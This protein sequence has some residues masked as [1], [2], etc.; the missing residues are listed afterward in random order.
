MPVLQSGRLRLQASS[1]VLRLPVLNTLL[2]TY[3][4]DLSATV[5]RADG[6]WYLCDDG[7]VGVVPAPQVR[8]AQAFQLFY[9]RADLAVD[10]P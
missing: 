8:Q 10:S 3:T 7:W 4:V 9:A 1:D 2:S 6:Q 5:C